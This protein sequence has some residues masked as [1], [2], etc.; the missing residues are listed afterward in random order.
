MYC[1]PAGGCGGLATLGPAG[2]L[3][4]Y[5]SGRAYG[6]ASFSLP[7]GHTSHV[8]IHVS[9]GLMTQIRRN[10]GASTLL[11]VVMGGRTFTQTIRIKIF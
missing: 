6:H 2:G 3:S 10:H 1:R 7:G 9:A 11:T 5:G 8:P 4:G